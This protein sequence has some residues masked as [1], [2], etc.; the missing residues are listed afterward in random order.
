MYRHAKQVLMGCLGLSM[1]GLAGCNSVISPSYPSN[2]TV[3][4]SVSKNT[5]APEATVPTANVPLAATAAPTNATVSNVTHTEGAS[6]GAPQWNS[7]ITQAM[8][9]IGDRTSVFLQAPRDIQRRAD[10]VHPYLSAQAQAD[11]ESYKITLQ[12]TTTPLPVNSPQIDNN[13]QNGGLAQLVGGFGGKAYPSVATA[14]AALKSNE[15]RIPASWKPTKADL[16]YG[17]IGYVYNQSGMGIV[18]W[19]ERGWLFEVNNGT[20]IDDIALAKQVVAYVNQHLLPDTYGAMSVENAADGEHTEL[21][22]TV[23]ET[24]YNCWESHSALAAVNMAISMKPLP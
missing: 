7:A 3:E 19:R 15:S 20:V 23:G 11:V 5:T 17:I 22:W 21:E 8:D 12:Y 24:V 16:G 13:P 6:K 9:Y 4:N 2:G 1:L 14:R 18:D 10:A